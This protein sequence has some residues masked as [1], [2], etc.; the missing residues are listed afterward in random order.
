[1]SCLMRRY[2]I[3]PLFLILPVLLWAGISHAFE[4]KGQDCSKCHT[5]TKDEARDLLKEVIPN[6]KVVEVGPSPTKGS[7]EIFFESGGKKGLIYLDFSK[8]YL[9]SG[10]LI[11]VKDR[12]NLTQERFGELN[13]IDLSQ[14]PLDDALV[15]GDKTAKY[16]VIVFDD[17][18]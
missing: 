2:S 17:P 12:R 14:L 3:V 1:M 5:L 18:D 16:K 9:F 7:W 10:S 11:S 13:K 15:M 8:R 6:M 4:T